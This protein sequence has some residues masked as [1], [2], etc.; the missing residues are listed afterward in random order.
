MIIVAHMACN[1]ILTCYFP[2][3]MKCLTIFHPIQCM[4]HC[5]CRAAFV[6]EWLMLLCTFHDTDLI[7]ILFVFIVLFCLV[8]V[9]GGGGGGGVEA[10]SCT[11]RL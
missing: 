10:S 11:K 1:Y 8:G 3:S 4:V 7:H 2:T 6:P 9:G 5:T